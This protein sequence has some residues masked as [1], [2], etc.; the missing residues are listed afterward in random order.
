[1]NTKYLNTELKLYKE[2]STFNILLFIL[3][4][5]I[6]DQFEMY[7]CKFSL[8]VEQYNFQYIGSISFHAK[9]F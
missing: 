3:V 7:V 5:L 8:W 1:M 4:R 9:F 2:I 6:L